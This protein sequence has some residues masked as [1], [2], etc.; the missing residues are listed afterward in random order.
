MSIVNFNNAFHA[1][2][3][4]ESGGGIYKLT[5]ST[6][7]GGYSASE[8]IDG[9]EIMT[10]GAELYRLIG[11]DTWVNMYDCY[12]NGR[13]GFKTSTNMITWTAAEGSTKLTNGDTFVPR[14]GSVIPIT[15][16]EYTMLQNN[17]VWD[18]RP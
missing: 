11:T 16:E 7:D 12:D 6:I 1:V 18:V 5:S 17:T 4:D 15:Q 8:R 3:K 14:H 13:F 10:E 9:E 2:I